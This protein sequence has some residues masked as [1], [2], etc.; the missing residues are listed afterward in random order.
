MNLKEYIAKSSISSLAKVVGVAPTVVYQWANE[1][2]PVPVKRCHC[3]V[4]ATN[5]A[6]TLK[7][8]RPYDWHLIWPE[9]ADPP[10]T[11]TTLPTR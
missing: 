7:D 8:L 1:I 10:K 9:L 2:R 3:V 4:V 6:V 11:D 5:G